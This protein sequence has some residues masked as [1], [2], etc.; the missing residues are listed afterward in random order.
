MYSTLEFIPR[1]YAMQLK[2]QFCSPI[3]TEYNDRDPP[4]RSGYLPSLPLNVPFPQLYRSLEFGKIERG[5][6]ASKIVIA[7]S[8]DKKKV[9]MA[10]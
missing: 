1:I 7:T 9:R 6:S 3:P 2:G 5:H 8:E 4:F 10:P